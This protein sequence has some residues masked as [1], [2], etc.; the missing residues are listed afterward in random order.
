MCTGLDLVAFAGADTE[1]RREFQN[2]TVG[3]VV[4]PL[5]VKSS[6]ADTVGI[7]ERKISITQSARSPTG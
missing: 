2:G 3:N 4:S 5:S 1:T 7:P 6:D